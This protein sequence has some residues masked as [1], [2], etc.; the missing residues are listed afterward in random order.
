[1]DAYPRFISYGSPPVYCRSPSALRADVGGLSSF[2]CDISLSCLRLGNFQELDLCPALHRHYTSSDGARHRP[3]GQKVCL[4]IRH[5]K[6]PD[7]R[8]CTVFLCAG[9]PAHS[10]EQVQEPANVFK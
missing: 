2:R 9:R 8:L 6:A 4:G 10:L 1:M 7:I 3:L 5:F